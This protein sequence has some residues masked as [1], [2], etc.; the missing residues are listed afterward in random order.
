MD[1][2]PTTAAK[3]QF[4]AFILLLTAV[5]CVSSTFAWFVFST[6]PHLTNIK[7]TAA[8]NGSLRIALMKDPEETARA[9]D[10]RSRINGPGTTG[11]STAGDPYTWGNLLDMAELLQGGTGDGLW[12]ASFEAEGAVFRRP[13]Y[14]TDGRVVD[15]VALQDPATA[16]YT[17][18][19]EGFAVIGVG[20][21]DYLLRLDFWLRTNVDGS[22][23]LSDGQSR[24]GGG[25]PGQGSYLRCPALAD[26]PPETI[27]V[28]F[29]ITDEAGGGEVWKQAEQQAGGDTI[30]LTAAPLFDAQANTS[31]RVQA[32]VYVNGLVVTNQYAAKA[33]EDLELNL[34]FSHSEI[35][36][37]GGVEPL[38]AP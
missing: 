28:V 33:I 2:L 31:Y 26:F 15:T 30:A 34:Q 37:A 38:P 7:A 23:S 29:R 12:P 27:G 16:P 22:I 19:R 17:E 11:G 1:R 3:L 20:E 6:N 35:G 14:G 21:K 9:V 24:G 18:G 32:Y 36:T 8:A 25:E 13:V 10:E 4:M 5:L